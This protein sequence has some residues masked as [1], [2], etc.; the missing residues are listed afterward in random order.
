MSQGAAMSTTL[1]DRTEAPRVNSQDKL[2][3]RPRPET[4]AHVIRSDGEAI[5]I[6]R[7]LGAKFAEGAAL[8]DREGLLPLAE[9]DAF[10]QSGLWGINVPKAYGGAGVSYVALTEVI[11]IISAADPSL[12]QIPQNHL[13]IVECISS[14]G[15]E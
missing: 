4:P 1:L 7:L 8:R 15:T 13:A 9:L 2:S 6:A 14:D 11:K 10:S 12:G 5:E 3:P